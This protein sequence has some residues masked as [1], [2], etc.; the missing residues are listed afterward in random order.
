[1]EE[2]VTILNKNGK[3]LFGIIH[4]PDAKNA[5]P[6]RVGVNILNPG[7]KHRVAPHRLNVKLARR[8]CNQGYY[9][10]RFD[11]EGI[12]DSE[13][14]LPDNLL[15]ADIW[16][17]IQKGLFITDVNAANDFFI[18]KCSLEHLLLIGNCGGAI[19]A[20][21]ASA[22]D[23]RVNGLALIDVPVNLRLAQQTFVDKVAPGSEK[24]DWL[25]LEYL[26]RV[27]RPESWYRFI[28]LQTD[29]KALYKTLI[30]KSNKHF[31]HRTN[32]LKNMILSNTVKNIT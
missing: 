30:L 13:G 24:A 28:T 29:Y 8:L 6:K 7:I 15:T 19:T 14:E 18:E 26:K 5:P 25:F 22:K 21:I 3:K 12:G 1:M 32:R 16:E 31:F 20:L 27:I 10:L 17:Q 9:V 11:P 4:I 2:P 23:N